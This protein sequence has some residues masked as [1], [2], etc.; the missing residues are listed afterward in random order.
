MAE[1]SKNRFY[2]YLIF[3]ILYALMIFYLSS[4]QT[5]PTPLDFI[6]F[7]ILLKIAGF[8]E[9][10]GLKLLLAPFY[11]AYLHL[12]KFLHVVLYAGLGFLLYFTIS[13]TKSA[14]YAPILVLMI[15]T[16]Y[17]ITDEVHQSFVVGRSASFFDLFADIIGISL[18]IMAVHCVKLLKLLL[19]KKVS[20]IDTD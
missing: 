17:G 4:K 11:L 8:I 7:D 2:V 20:Y 5:I 3:V 6:G 19:H 12:D 15:G 10:I 14:K 18:A 1:N 16:I 9:R 13:N